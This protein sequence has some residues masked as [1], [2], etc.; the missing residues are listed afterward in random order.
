[1]DDERELIDRLCTHAGMIMEDASAH[2][3]DIS[4]DADQLRTKL[5][6]L[7]RSAAD[8]AIIIAAAA[9]LLERQSPPG[10]VT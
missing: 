8:V 9:A 10:A 3:V 7:R 6:G 1:M 4:Q 5:E 2:A